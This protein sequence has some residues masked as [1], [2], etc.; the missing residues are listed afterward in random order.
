MK[1]ALRIHPGV[2]LP[3]ERLVP[4]EGA[5]ICD[6]HLP[7]DTNVFMMAPVMH[8]DKNIYGEDAYEFRPERWLE[9]SPEQLK[10]ME[11][12]FLAVRYTL[13]Q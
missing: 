3:L 8:M 11:R 1:E 9:A 10:A 12:S 4:R 7:A 2:G 13:A 6:V 5:T